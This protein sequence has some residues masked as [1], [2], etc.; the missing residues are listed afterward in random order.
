M[1]VLESKLVQLRK[2]PACE[3]E[4]EPVGGAISPILLQVEHRWVDGINGETRRHV[5][6]SGT[7]FTSVSI[8]AFCRYTW[9]ARCEPIPLSCFASFPSFV[10]MV[11]TPERCNASSAP[12]PLLRK[13]VAPDRGSPSR[14][15]DMRLTRRFNAGAARIL[16]HT[17]GYNDLY[18]QGFGALPQA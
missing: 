6:I 12:Y 5:T 14:W 15:N 1:S 3:T 11:S 17:I 7:M 2:V 4:H 8:E 13:K 16:P 9:N 10:A 18:P